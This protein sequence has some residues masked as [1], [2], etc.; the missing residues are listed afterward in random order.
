MHSFAYWFAMT[1]FAVFIA[2]ALVVNHWPC[3][4]RVRDTE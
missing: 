4:I 3:E 2:V 1:W